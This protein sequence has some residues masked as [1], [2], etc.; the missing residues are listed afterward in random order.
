[1]Q[2]T[3]SSKCVRRGSVRLPKPVTASGRGRWQS[4]HSSL[5]NSSLR[6]RTSG[7]VNAIWWWLP[8]HSA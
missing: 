2:L 7:F 5:R 8:S 1:M 4:M 3:P 6:A